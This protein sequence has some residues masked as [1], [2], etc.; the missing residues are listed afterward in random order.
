MIAALAFIVL[1][2]IGLRGVSKDPSVDAFVPDDHPAAVARETAR[3]IFGLEDP[4]VVGLSMPEGESAFTPETL[5]AL[6]RLHE[7][8][9]TIDG[10]KKNDIVSLASENA[11]RGQGGDLLVDAI[12]PDGKITPELAKTSESRFH[13]MPMLAN[14][15]GSEAGDFLTLIVPVE[16][17]DHAA[18]AV[19]EIIDSANEIAGPHFESV[20]VAGVAA[21]NARL[22][23]MVNGDTKILVPGA[24]VTVLLIL[25]FALRRPKAVLGPLLVIAGSAAVAIGTMGWVGARYYLITTALPVVIMAIAVADSMHITIFYLRARREHPEI[26]AKRAMLQALNVT[27]LPVTLTS[28]TTIVAFIGLSFGAA[29]RPISEFG[30]FAACG[31]AAAWLLSFTLLPAVVILTDLRPAVA[32]KGMRPW[33][34]RL[35]EKISNW[36]FAHP[37][38]AGAATSLALMLLFVFATHANFDYERKRYFVAEDPVSIADQKINERLGG[39]NFLDVVVSARDEEELTTPAALKAIADLRLQ[40]EAMPFVENTSGIDQYM[41]LMHSVLMDEPYGA[42]PTKPRAPAQYLFLYESAGAPEDFKQEIDYEYKRALLRA[43]LSTD[44]YQLTKPTV[45]Q[46]KD[47][48]IQ[49][50]KDTGIDAQVSG[51]IA[52]NEGWMTRLSQNHFKGLGMAIVLVFFATLIALRSVGAAI[53]SMFP[54]LVGVLSVYATMGIFNISIAP[55]TSMTAAI[56]TGLGI[57][58]GIHLVSH[59]RR[60]ISSGGSFTSAFDEHYATVGRACVYSAVALGVALAVLCISSAPPLRWFGFLVSVGAVGSLLGAMFMIPALSPLLFRNQNVQK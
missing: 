8:L 35:L 10:V 60:V 58:F 26:D 53:L 49:W 15:L 46:L 40:M 31:V 30:Y 22:G 5:T 3:S 51:R 19:R 25:L 50:S 55:A 54:I 28:V 34:D 16:D 59:V 1:F 41:S 17:P 2:A 48:L 14:L 39:I 45:E 57:D 6:K 23:Q 27:A 42:L 37:I 18:D 47:N 44:Q 29:M 56:A 20:D 24:I 38:I 11:I 32:D 52:V 7:R 36:S 13:D 9:R 43:Q 4:A 21:M 33:I 12:V